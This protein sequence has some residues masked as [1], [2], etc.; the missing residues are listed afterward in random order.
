MSASVYLSCTTAAQ[1]VP[2]A[3]VRLTLDPAREQGQHDLSQGR[4]LILSKSCLPL[5]A[6]RQQETE[7]LSEPLALA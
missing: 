5:Y 4:M 1:T 6:I 2:T 3:T 7:V